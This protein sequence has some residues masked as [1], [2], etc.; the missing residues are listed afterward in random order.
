MFNARSRMAFKPFYEA[1][2]RGLPYREANYES[3]K[4]VM[5][6][7]YGEEEIRQHAQ[8]IEETLLSGKPMEMR[9]GD[10]RI[11]RTLY[12]RMSK[13]RYVA[14][15]TDITE[16]RLQ[17]KAL[18]DSRRQAEA[19]TQ[20]KAAFLANMSHEIRTPLNGI[21]GMAQVMVLSDLTPL[22]REQAEAIL[23]SGQA[24]KRLLDDVLDLAKIDAGRL[25]L[26]PTDC[27]LR[28]L[29]RQLARWRRRAEAKGLGFH[30]DLGANV[31]SAM[32][33]D[34]VRFGQCL[35][36][37]L[38]NAVKFTEPGG[39]VRVGISAQSLPDRIAV[40]VRVAD[41]GIGMSEEMQQRLFSPFTQGDSSISR[42][43]G[44]TGLGL[45][46]TRKL[47][48]LMGGDVTVESEEGK[49]SAF[50]LTFM[51]QPVASAADGRP[52]GKAPN[53]GRRVLFVDDHVINRRIGRLFLEPEGYVLTEAENG[54]EALRQLESGAFDL[55]LL[56]IQMPVLDGL[57][58]LQRIRQSGRS[59]AGI[60]VVALVADGAEEDCERYLSQGMSGCIG[61]P[62]EQRDLLAAVGRACGVTAPSVRE[63]APGM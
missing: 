11:Y 21:L 63:F 31:P 50:T 18:Q 60:P 42:R 57:Q 14:V 52:R 54:L 37:L 29:D 22:Q 24:L 49:G 56:D 10:G 48:A 3:V 61:K 33:L 1:V 20:A 32:R 27:D 39:E 47:A 38:S 25:V 17:Q 58:T 44:G 2:A 30:I 4:F 34:P 23:D 9:P 19:A 41:T 13:S 40:C 36:N 62:I 51:V 16:E 28:M 46:I 43:Y 6:G 53:A 55:V 15:S 12:R 45:V 5:Q 7:S 35:S 26:A 8:F 59:W